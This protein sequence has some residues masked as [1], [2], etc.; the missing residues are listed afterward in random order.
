M[1]KFS[2][3]TVDAFSTK[4]FHGN[5]AAIVPVPSG[6]SI[7]DHTMQ[8][9]AAEMNIAETS[10]FTP[11]QSEGPDEFQKSSRF[12]LRWFTPTVEAKLCGHATLAAA[13]VLFNELQNQ[14]N[15][16]HFDTLSGVLSVSINREGKL[17]MRLPMD[18]PEPV[19]HNDNFKEIATGVLGR[20]SSST[21]IALSPVL[22]YLVIHDAS[23]SE[24]EL[25][26]LVPNITTKVIEAGRRE[27]VD[28][29]MVTTK[30]SDRDF[31]SRVFAPWCG[32]D[33]DPVTGSAH[34]V[35]AL[36]WK[37]KLGKPFF[38]AQQCSKRCGELDVKIVDATHVVISGNAVVVIRG[39]LFL[40][41]E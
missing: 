18:K 32:I 7:P 39:E 29:V 12:A 11:V 23:F 41:L 38:V 14:N 6:Q 37:E 10:F 15:T 36:F 22:R 40:D 16:L 19:V 13:H 25:V 1:A 31:K 26:A 9:L 30:G 2:I 33:E 35:L 5:Q 17:T 27:R 28:L 8:A 24:E 34:T 4:P 3:Y 21:E 20:C